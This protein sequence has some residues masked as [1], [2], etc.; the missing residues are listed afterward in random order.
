M[1]NN[2][3]AYKLA[4]CGKGGSGKSTIA[5]LLAKALVENGNSVLVIDTDESNFGLHRQLGVDL[6]PDFMEYFGGK[7]AVLEKIMQAAPEWDS[8]SFFEGKLSFADIPQAYLSENGEV[9]LLA[10][11]KIHEVGE[12]CA[13]S[14]GILVKEFIEKLRLNHGE[15]VI[16]DTEA[17]IEH[18]GRGIEKSV[19]AILM[20]IDP[21]Y[22]SLRLSEKVA[23]LSGSIGKPIF[24][25]LN[26]VDKSN[27]QF[28]WEAIGDRHTVIAAIPADPTLSLAGLRGEEVMTRNTEV[29]HILQVLEEKCIYD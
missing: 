21:S 3:K 2:K 15:V 29:Q 9:K 19:D 1:M 25:V 17:G 20:V 7:S 22:E 13:C 8:V 4:I 23:E 10:I 14:M 5:A 18:F 28:M 16:V 11:G 27:E 26:K 12:G 6:P 24:F